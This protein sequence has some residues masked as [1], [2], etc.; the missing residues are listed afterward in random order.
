L[1]CF[2][3]LLGKEFQRTTIHTGSINQKVATE[4]RN[5]QSLERA[6]GTRWRANQTG[7]GLVIEVVVLSDAAWRN[8][9]DNSEF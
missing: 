9:R 5:A 8:A 7:L 4:T 2:G 1:A 3:K 6:K